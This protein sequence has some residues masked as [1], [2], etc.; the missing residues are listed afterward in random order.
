M[1]LLP[2]ASE[3][4]W[5]RGQLKPFDCKSLIAGAM[6]LMVIGLLGLSSGL[7]W[8]AAMAATDAGQS[9]YRMDS[10]GM[11]QGLPQENLTSVLQT[12]DGYLW[13]G[14]Y[15][16][17]SRFDGVRF[18]NYNLED[19]L[20]VKGE[21]VRSLFEDSSGVLWIGTTYGLIRHVGE[22][23]EYIADTPHSINQIWG[24]GQGGLWVAGDTGLFRY[25]DGK[26][27]SFASNPL[28]SDRAASSVFVDSH[29]R[30]W[31]GFVRSRDLICY[32]KG[33]FRRIDTQGAITEAVNGT[34]ETQDGTLWF[35]TG[36]FGTDSGGLVFL[37]DGRFTR[38]DPKRSGFWIRALCADAR[39]SLWIGTTGLKKLSPGNG[40][41]VE[42]DLPLPTA[43]IRSICQDRE[44]NTWVATYGEGLLRV[45]PVL[46]RLLNSNSGL[47]SDLIRTVMQDSTGAMWLG[48]ARAGVARI[49]PDGTVT[50][51]LPRA[52]L[53]Q[54]DVTSVYVTRSGD[55]WF[56]TG[57]ALYMQRGGQTEAHPEFKSVRA[58]FEDSRGRIWFGLSDDGLVCWKAG[59]F[60]RVSLPEAVAKC[61]PCSF[62]EDPVHDILYA[63]TVIDGVLKLQG[64]RVTVINSTTGLP[65]DSVRAVLLDADGNL[66]V[67]I[68]GAGL[69]VFS[70]GRWLAPAWVSETIDQFVSGIV[71]INQGRDFL[72]GT[73]RGLLYLSRKDVLAALHQPVAPKNFRVVT[74]SEPSRTGSIGTACF[75]GFWKTS[76]GE[77][78][79]AARKG[80][81]IVDPADIKP[82]ETV[83]PVLVERILVDEQAVS[84]GQAIR[85][86][87]GTRHLTI[88]YTALSFVRSDRISF[89]Y[90]LDGYDTDWIDGGTRRVASY[91]N[92]PPGDY[93]FIVKARNSDGL[94]NDAGD[95]ISIVQAP[96][97]YQTWWFYVFAA[98]GAGVLGLTTYRWRTAHMRREKEHLEKRIKER[99]QQLALAKEAAEQAEAKALAAK[100]EAESASRSKSMFLANMSHEI[101]TPMNGVIG[102]T[103]LLLDTRLDEEQLSYAETVKKS[104]EALLAIINDILDFSKIEAGKLELERGDFSPRE[105]VEDA[106]ELL[107]EVAQRKRI[108][109]VYWI[110][111]D[112][113]ADVVGDT[114][115]F[116]QILI[117]LVGNAIKFTDRGEVMV[118]MS[119]AAPG[120]DGSAV[121]R[122][123]ISDTG[124]GMDAA[125][126]ARLFQSFTQVDGSTAR[127][128]GGTGLGLAISKQLAELMGGAIG[129]ESEPGQGSTF[130]FTAAFG[131]S[132]RPAAVPTPNNAFA[133]RHV[134]IV[135]DNLTNR[136]LL[137]QFLRC[138]GATAD[139]A[140]DGKAALAKMQEMSR[141]GRR[142]D[143]VLLDY[144][145]P[146]MDGLELASRIRDDPLISDA[147]LLLL[148]SSLSRDHREA[149]ESLKIFAVFQK[150]VR[151]AP[152]MRT[153][154]RLW[155][156]ETVQKAGEHMVAKV[157]KSAMAARILLVE[158][159]AVNQ[160]LG[161]RMVEK[162]GHRV[163]LAANGKEALDATFLINYDLIL[164][165][166]QMPE[167][168][169]YEAT[170]EIRKREGNG[171]HIAIVAMTANV[172]DGEK[173]H[174]LS[175]GMNDYLSKPIRMPELAQAIKRWA[176]NLNGQ[177][178][179]EP[180]MAPGR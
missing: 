170:Q 46:S 3:S 137:T 95:R 73:S 173:E 153:L 82:V 175:V 158:D 24:D 43:N 143:A 165:D 80:V 125:G 48:L 55:T 44:G 79:F 126:K 160:M 86:A 76:S 145:M 83:P 140:V 11:E 61:S 23:F 85:L 25:Q 68:K 89:A 122:I 131:R 94:W 176:R 74:I 113:P 171:S 99:T 37:R 53:E 163:D 6:K 52:L 129:V 57:K 135:D 8:P 177:P 9:N 116:R 42:A 130:W 58:I 2:S 159:N 14:S 124:I 142:F 1:A 38:L 128:H 123:E 91:T 36:S 5:P 71:E 138:G 51:P 114:G 172:I 120:G 65:G 141:S 20:G 117:N 62:A 156:G 40:E 180:E 26:L 162:L 121:L 13:I 10:W 75:P 115:R 32:E 147:S 102:M 56:G 132:N 77:V 164:M 88:E 39:G 92:L 168:D 12:R 30:V 161:R 18:V 174:C 70:D 28:V 167:M 179:G 150:P 178:G 148:S 149:I 166:C 27:D 96:Y 4:Q 157:E 29:G 144:Q 109:L 63:G 15:A 112:V 108:E 7:P 22:K 155:F 146:D 60:S 59:V 107:S 105:A 21:E 119:V 127:R 47:P 16:N 100:A 90:K 81:I 154:H 69:T 104:G 41:K 17:L 84:R 87:P 151:H 98:A 19:F 103:G 118:K 134:L 64:D 78:W 72:L 67:G 35:G 93:T 139:E 97:F 136:R 33:V 49:A 106:L 169:G 54:E 34:C 101:R 31:I 50:T 152:L 45:R 111:D 110:D 66:W 133:G